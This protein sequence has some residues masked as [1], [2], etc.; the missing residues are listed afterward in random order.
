MVRRAI[1]L[2]CA[3][4]SEL[5]GEAIEHRATDLSEDGL[6]IQ[7]ELLLEVGSEVTLTFRPPDWEEPLYVAG[8]VQR[9]E[10]Q[11]R[12][13]GESAVGMGIEFDALRTDERRR[14]TR[15]MRGL[16][17]RESFILDQHTLT[18]VPVGVAE[19]PEP[20]Q[21]AGETIVGWASPSTEPGAERPSH[22]RAIFPS[23][24]P[25]PDLIKSAFA[26]GL[27]LA[28]SVFATS[29]SD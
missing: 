2:E 26:G 3:V 13:G 8:R 10:L 6:W 16:P 28:T 23:S 20:A 19:P 7:T 21:S 22:I 29:G 24:E 4:Y 15:S 17:A 1:E 27:D 14:L 9:V 5:W 18:G 25:R 11:Q 12:P